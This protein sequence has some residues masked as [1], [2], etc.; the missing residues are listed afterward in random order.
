MPDMF[1]SKQ[2]RHRIVYLHRSVHGF[3]GCRDGEE[4]GWIRGSRQGAAAFFGF[5]P[6]LLPVSACLT[7]CES[8]WGCRVQAAWIEC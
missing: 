8:M 1:D 6:A 5:S 7:I 3:V 2:W 4:L